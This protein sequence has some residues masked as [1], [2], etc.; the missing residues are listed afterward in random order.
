MRS[1]QLPWPLVSEVGKLSG[2]ERLSR[3]WKEVQKGVASAGPS[4]SYEFQA[5]AFDIW[6]LPAG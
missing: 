2:R 6:I 1:T 5:L 3:V 4:A